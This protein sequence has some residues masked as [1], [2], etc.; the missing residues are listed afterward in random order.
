MTDR[1]RPFE[2]DRK[3]EEDIAEPGSEPFG[4]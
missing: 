2:C 4:M 3:A 1:F